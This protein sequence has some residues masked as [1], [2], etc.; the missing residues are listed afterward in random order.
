MKSVTI[1]VSKPARQMLARGTSIRAEAAHR[2]TAIIAALP[3]DVW[4]GDGLAN[5][6]D[7]LEKADTAFGDLR[8]SSRGIVLGETHRTPDDYTLLQA[9]LGNL[10]RVGLRPAIY[11][12]GSIL[13][14]DHKE[15]L[16][17]C[18]LQAFIATSNILGKGMAENPPTETA[19]R[20]GRIAVGLGV[21]QD[22]YGTINKT[23]LSQQ[24]QTGRA[25]KRI[26]CDIPEGYVTWL[27]GTAKALSTSV[28]KL[29]GRLVEYSLTKAGTNNPAGISKEILLNR[30]YRLV[31]VLIHL[32]RRLLSLRYVLEG[33][34]AEA[35]AAGNPFNEDETINAIK[36]RLAMVE[37][38]LRLAIAVIMRQR[39]DDGLNLR[40]LQDLI[41]A[42]KKLPALLAAPGEENAK[43]IARYLIALRFLKVI[44]PQSK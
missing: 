12:L 21:V 19:L 20:F 37:V 3:P 11:H 41:E 17:K 35:E 40:L 23:K 25:C 38:T 1:V 39:P 18:A 15:S 10:L 8:R 26:S 44:N 7:A 14:A 24:I 2:L 43:A 33:A 22:P 34:K 36:H 32:A 4:Q 30:V 13:N 27:A 31:A 28:T 6:T 5:A 9:E 42:K 29:G 16:E